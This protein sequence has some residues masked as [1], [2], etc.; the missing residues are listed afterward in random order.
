MPK[1]RRALSAWIAGH[2][3][4]AI[5]STNIATREMF[6]QMS[7]F[8]QGFFFWILS[9]LFILKNILQEIFRVIYHLFLVKV[10][11]LLLPQSK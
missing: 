1:P 9:S 8:G 4:S 11:P 10:F 7:L 5:R 2:Y 3:F 6:P